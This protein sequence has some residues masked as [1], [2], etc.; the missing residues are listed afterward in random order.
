MKEELLSLLLE[1][2]NDNKSR[3]NEVERNTNQPD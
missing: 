1:N 3:L 2:V